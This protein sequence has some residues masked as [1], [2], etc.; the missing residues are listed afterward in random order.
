[1]SM[2]GRITIL[3]RARESGFIKSESGHSYFFDSSGVMQYD[4]AMLVVGETV[5]FDLGSGDRMRAVNVC[6]RKR[7]Q[8]LHSD[9]TKKEPLRLR[10]MGFEQIGNLREYRF[11]RMVKGR[12]TE[13]FAMTADLALLMKHSVSIQDGPGLCLR[14]LTAGLEAGGAS[15][16]LRTVTDAEVL[17]FAAARPAPKTRPGPR[18]KPAAAQETPS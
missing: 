7:T 16:P 3:N 18:K 9:E 13:S 4:P 8:P 17:A 5:T 6:C 12:E 2:T 11:E 10:Y 1:M 15:G 14:L